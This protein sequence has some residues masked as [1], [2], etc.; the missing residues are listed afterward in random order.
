MWVAPVD[1]KEEGAT[2][3][4][5]HSGI[6]CNM[7]GRPSGALKCRIGCAIQVVLVEREKMLVKN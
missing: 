7:K 4:Q 1:L 2:L 5:E 3:I 6:V